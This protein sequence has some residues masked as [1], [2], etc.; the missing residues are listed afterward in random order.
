MPVGCSPELSNAVQKIANLTQA[1]KFSD[2][3]A[4]LRL[5]PGYGIKVEWDDSAVAEGSRFDFA[6]QRD[7]VIKEWTGRMAL[8]CTL[9]SQG[10]DV[11]VRFGDD[12]GL[13]LVWSENPSEPRLTARIGLK[14]GEGA[15]DPANLRNEFSFALGSYYGVAKLPIETLLMSG[16]PAGTLPIPVSDLEFKIAIGNLNA[17]ERVRSQVNKSVPLDAGRPALAQTPAPIDLGTVLQ[18]TLV[19]FNIG[20]TNSGTGSLNYRIV[21]DC[22]CFASRGPSAVPPG[23]TVLAEAFMSTTEFTGIVQGGVLHHKLYLFTNDPAEPIRLIPVVIRV[24]P[25]YRM[26]PDRQV[27][28][29]DD[30][31]EVTF[32]A[33]LYS[34][35]DHPISVTGAESSGLPG[36]VKF[37][38]W[39]G[40]IDDPGMNEGPLPRK[41]YKFTLKLKNVPTGMQLGTNISITTG[42]S[43]FPLINYPVFVQRGIIA[44]PQ[45][46]FMGE[47]GAAP[48]SI[49]FKLTRPGKA[50]NIIS[51]DTDSAHLKA[52]YEPTKMI[53]EYMVTVAY[54]GKAASGDY[55]GTVIIKTDD[56][57]QKEIDVAVTGTVR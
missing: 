35:Q 26:R 21:P 55:R 17:C 16:P 30:K 44:L 32:E 11:K 19:K 13:S 3:K 4:A 56:P 10:A 24:Q 23:Q 36:E 9:V 37:E 45:S 49:A 8:K 48:R 2:A 29:A 53:G 31:G 47:V 6:K 5:L 27:I 50:F 52:T 42:D 33:F 46:V 12:R 40:V 22:S 14:V 28:I 54:D 43:T 25:R 20:I 57:L 38:P 41:G 15:L 39:D 51:V 1:G 7:D 18:G 34:P